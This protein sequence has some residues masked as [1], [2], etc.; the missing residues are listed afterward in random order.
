[1]LAKI[2]RIDFRGAMSDTFNGVSV[3]GRKVAVNTAITYGRSIIGMLFGLFSSRWIL[4]SLGETDFGLYGL[5]G[6][7]IVAVS[8]VNLVLSNATSRF[9]AVAV[10]ERDGDLSG[11]FNAA[12]SV[13]VVL[14]L[15]VL[16][17]G[18]PLGEYAIG[19]WL[20]I[21]D[22]RVA[23]CR[24]V[25]TMSL[26]ATAAGVLSVPYSAMFTARQKFG[27]L[28][29]YALLGSAF[30]CAVAGFMRSSSGDRLIC[31]SVLVSGLSCLMSVVQS[32]RAR[33]RFPEC[34]IR[35]AK[36]GDS[37]KARELVTY[38]GWRILGTSGW[39]A[40]RQGA[41]FVVNLAFG[42]AA[43]AAYSIAGQFAV[44][45]SSLTTALSSAVTPAIAT[46]LGR[47]D[48]TK[49]ADMVLASCRF[50]GFLAA[51]IGIPLAVEANSVL[52]IWLVTPP[53][54]AWVLATLFTVAMILDSSTAGIAA[55]LGANRDVAM[56]QTFAFVVLA[57]TCPVAWMCFKMGFGLASLGFIFVAAAC[58]MTVGR[59][60]FAKKLLGVM[61]GEWKR[62]VA[63]PLAGVWV[64]SALA[65]LSLHSF[66]AEGLVRVVAVG[67]GALATTFVASYFILFTDKEKSAICQ[68][69]L[70]RRL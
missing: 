61:P 36:L 57:V 26:V 65:S 22:G 50:M 4:L 13:H 29:A 66:L 15:I 39:L 21:P 49:T 14:A 25:F 33:I 59:V 51:L 52:K 45:A 28:A 16:L 47:G 9:Y 63:L 68:T 24:V 41:A 32:V 3:S 34:S 40:Q 6:S 11:W 10:G 23:A 69:L 35:L 55:G 38:S 64:V 27:E 67:L 18:F 53:A 60:C 43:N 54:G 19:N 44:H 5:V 58:I 8:F 56:W 17:V 48:E 20:V 2:C 70:Q 30:T 31:F 62:K 12:V 1:M 7:L 46:M 42:A 37:G